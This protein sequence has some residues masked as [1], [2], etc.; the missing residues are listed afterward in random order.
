MNV[1]WYPIIYIEKNRKYAILKKK[2]PSDENIKLDYSIYRNK[3]QNLI[4]YSKKN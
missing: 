3:L 2:K 1:Y 4:E